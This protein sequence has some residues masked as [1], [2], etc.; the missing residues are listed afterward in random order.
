M[1]EVN[2][3]NTEHPLRAA[4]SF[5]VDTDPCRMTGVTSYKLLGIKFRS[6]TLASFLDAET[7]GR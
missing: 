4:Y 5:S 1:Y 6:M 3:S 7:I 2:V